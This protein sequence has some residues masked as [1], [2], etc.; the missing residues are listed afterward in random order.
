MILARLP[1]PLAL[2]VVFCGSMLLAVLLA[3][4]AL[5]PLL[6]VDSAA[7]FVDFLSRY[8]TDLI[9]SIVSLNQWIL[10]VFAG[11]VIWSA[12]AVLFLAPIT[13]KVRTASETRSL[14]TSVIAAIVVGALLCGILAASAVE[15]VFALL[16]ADAKAF[17]SSFPGGYPVMTSF[18][19]AGWVGGGFV[20]AMLLRG[21]SGSRNPNHLE[22]ILRV[23]FAGTVVELVLGIPIYLLVRRKSN[24]ECALASFYSLC[25][26][27]AALLWLCGPWA[28]LF[29]TRHARK[30]WLRGACPEC[31]YPRRTD[32]T[33]CSECGAAFPCSGSTVQ[34]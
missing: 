9:P 33:V 28:I 19:L 10:I 8:Y 13:G 4:L 31:G 14:L 27:V 29:L 24:C 17:E 15:L 22:R 16:A 25:L 7:S 5:A 34:S 21:V 32:A 6:L 20:V 30:G 12:I 11:A 2:V 1:R 3:P 18:M 26:G 23:I